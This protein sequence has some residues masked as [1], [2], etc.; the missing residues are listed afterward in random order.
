MGWPVRHSLSPRLHGFWLEQYGINGSYKAIAVT[1]DDFTKYLRRLAAEGFAG[2]NITVPHKEAALAAVDTVDDAARRIGAVNT[3]VMGAD[4][5][6]SGTNT[7]GFGFLENVKE[8]ATNFQPGQGPTVILGAGGAARAIAVALIDAGAPEVRIT[9]RTQARAETLAKQIGGPIK[10]IPWQ[11][12]NDAMADATL[13][14]NT[15]ILGMQNQPR[16]EVDLKTLPI[17][18]LVTDIVYAPLE[19][20]LLKS[21][22][23]RGNGT[24]DGLGM[25]LHQARPGFEAWFGIKPEVSPA[26]REHV[27][28]EIKG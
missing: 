13:L 10:V 1:P 22:R 4:G 5:K 12:R 18:A 6:L 19:T 21:A 23:V 7:D 20:D 28:A 3:I 16:L 17:A 27:L 9:N 24:V 25:L 8:G 15:T 2:V 11:N 14:V 26:L